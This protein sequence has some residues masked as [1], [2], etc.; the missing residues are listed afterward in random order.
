MLADAAHLQ[1]LS[2]GRQVRLVELVWHVPPDGPELAPLLDDGVQ[3]AQHK[4]Q[5]APVW[6]VDRIQHVLQHMPSNQVN[7]VVKVAWKTFWSCACVAAVPAAI[8]PQPHLPLRLM[9]KGWVMQDCGA[10]S[11]HLRCQASC[12]YCFHRHHPLRA[13]LITASPRGPFIPRLSSA[14]CCWAAHLGQPLEG[15]SQAGL[16]SHGSLVGQLQADVQQPDGEGWVG[17]C[18]DPQP[19]ALVQA[20]RPGQDGLHL[21][22]QAVAQQVGCCCA[23]LRASAVLCCSRRPAVS[24]LCSSKPRQACSGAAASQP[25][26]PGLACMQRFMV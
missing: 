4:Q 25:G 11:L 14:A 19:E 1:E 21:C 5:L 22:A 6:P 17:L 20:L 26:R 13:G 10:A 24:R 2:A 9:G 7:S 12:I 23:L 18:G 16:D 3:V 15:G 8:T